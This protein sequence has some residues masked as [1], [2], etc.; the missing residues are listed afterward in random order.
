VSGVLT[1]VPQ[2]LADTLRDIVAVLEPLIDAG[3]YSYLLSGVNGAAGG[4]LY[5]I[6]SRLAALDTAEN[7]LDADLTGT[8]YE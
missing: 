4:W 1:G 5:D 8:T 7:H 6:G 2:N 3:D